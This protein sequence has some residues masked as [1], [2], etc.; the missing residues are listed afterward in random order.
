LNLL[1]SASPSNKEAIGPIERANDTPALPAIAQTV[2]DRPKSRDSISE[3]GFRF[4]VIQ[5]WA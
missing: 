5:K 1:P 4:A 2:S 3:T